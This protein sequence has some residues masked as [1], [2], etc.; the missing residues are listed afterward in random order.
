MSKGLQGRLLPRRWLLHKLTNDF[1]VYAYLA[2]RIVIESII[3]RRVH[4][5]RADGNFY[6]HTDPTKD[7]SIEIRFIVSPN[8]FEKWMNSFARPVSN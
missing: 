4:F 5:W 6:L 3:A 8:L 1:K 7:S 2:P